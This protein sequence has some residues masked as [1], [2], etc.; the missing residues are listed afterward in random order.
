MDSLKSN[1]AIVNDSGVII[2]V[3]ES[4]NRFALQNGIKSLDK[5]GVGAN[6]FDVCR[7]ARGEGS[8]EAP[9]ALDGLLSVLNGRISNFELE[10][11]CD[12]PDRKC[13]FLMRATR[14]ID[15]GRQYLV[16]NHIDITRRKL[17]EIDLIASYH[18]I[19]ARLNEEAKKS[20]DYSLACKE[21]LVLKKRLEDALHE[22]EE[23]FQNL[24]ER[25]PFAVYIYRGDKNCCYV[26]PAAEALTGYTKDEFVNMS[27]WDIA[28]PDYRELVKER[29]MKRQKG[30]S[31]PS[32]YQ[33]RIITKSGDERWI[34]LN[35]SAVMF[36]RKP[37]ILV[38]MADITDQKHV[39][40]VL[41]D[42]RAQAEVYIDLM[43]HDINNMNQIAMGNLELFIDNLR[44]GLK[45]EDSDRQLLDNSYATLR[46][47][48]KL[49]ENVRKIQRVKTGDLKPQMIDIGL[50]IAELISVYSNFPGRNVIIRFNPVSGYMVKACELF[51]DVFVNIVDNAIKH[52]S[53]PLVIDIIINELIENGKKFYRIIIEDN[54]PGIPDNRKQEIFERFKR[55]D[56]KARGHGLGLYLVKTLVE[57]FGGKV[58]AEDRIPGEYTKGS[59]FVILMPAIEK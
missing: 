27:F 2:D 35:A 37:A 47:I 48:S 56:T 38:T 45:V 20:E 18:D 15:N 59:K 46:N 8:D 49:I 21:S 53:G 32:R 4:W 14:F 26:N 24:L 43:S 3:N 33:I 41:S 25:A 58:W 54:G 50:M 57:D 31:V 51:Q 52:S 13:W 28:H 19:E 1:V 44:G 42:A 22:S 16:V 30:E 55:G 6:Y 11:P 39:E 9:V 29:G 17:A 5:V 36:E 34:D 12:S 7:K 23:K 40:E 10:Y